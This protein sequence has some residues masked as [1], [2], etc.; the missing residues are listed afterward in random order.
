MNA[1]RAGLLVAACTAL[2]VGPA[3]AVKLPGLG[4]PADREALRPLR[5]ADL[6]A[7][8]RGE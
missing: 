4:T 5:E 6:Q 1:A 8:S 7:A 3:V 2:G